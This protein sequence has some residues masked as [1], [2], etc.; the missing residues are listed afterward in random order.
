MTHYFGGSDALLERLQ[1]AVSQG[2]QIVFVVGSPLTAP[3]EH[4]GRGVM[5]VDAVVELIREEFSANRESRDL[6]NSALKA[7]G[8]KSYQHAFE[9][10]ILRRGVDYANQIVRRAVQNSYLGSICRLDDASNLEAAERDIENWHLSPAVESLGRIL[11]DRDLRSFGTTLTTNFDPLIQIAIARAGGSSY[12]TMLHREGNLA[13]TRADAAHIVHLHGSWR[14]SD[15][16]HTSRQLLQERPQLK[17]SLSSVAKNALIV[18]IGYG[19]W[20]DII[21]GT[22]SEL[23]IDDTSYPE[24]AW[25]FYGNSHADIVA[26]NTDIL[27]KLRAGIDRGRVSLYSGIDCHQFFPNLERLLMQGSAKPK[28]EAHESH[29]AELTVEQ[30]KFAALIDEM[31]AQ[32]SPIN[33]VPRTDVWFGRDVEL[34]RIRQTRAGVVAITG[35]GGQGKSSLASKYFGECKQDGLFEFFDW[36]DCREQGNTI[37][38]AICSTIEKATNGTIK[39][40]DIAKRPVNELSSILTRELRDRRALL[41]FDNVDHY[42]DLETNEPLGALKSVVEAVLNDVSGI[43]LIFTARPLVCIEHPDFVELRLT[44]LVEDEAREL[45]Q[46]RYGKTIDPEVFVKLFSLTAGHPLW[47]SIIA[48][49]CFGNGASVESILSSFQN[50]GIELPKQMLRQTWEGLN[51][52]QQHVLR[53]LAELERPESERNIEDITELNYNK[54][55]KALIK[56]RSLC[57]IERK[58]ANGKVEVIDLHPLIRQFVREE[59]PRKERESFIGKVIIY[60]DK[61][62]FQ[63]KRKP[64]GPIP[65]LIL[66]MWVHKIDLLINSNLYQQAIDGLFEVM[67][68]LDHNGFNEEISRLAKRIFSSI[69][70][71]E[72][73]SAYGNFDKLFN[74][75]M[76]AIV[77]VEGG[78]AVNEW[79]M[80]YEES[81]AG[82]GAQYINF[83]DLQ[84]YKHWFQKDHVDAIVWAEKGEA[85]KKSSNVD[86]SFQCSHTLAL[87]QRDSG[88][89]EPAFEYFKDGLSEE[90]IFSMESEGNR[91]GPF[92]G[93]LG[94]CYYFMGN[95][96]QAFKAYQ[97]SARRLDDGVSSVIDQ[98]YIRH[99][100]GQLL[101]TMGR[102]EDAIY[103]FRA[104]TEK[105]QRIAPSLCSDA[106]VEIKAI[107][108]DHP[109]LRHAEEAP[110][111]RCENRF[112][113]WVVEK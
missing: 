42:I 73:V 89:L 20:D 37:N 76:R 19:G 91:N 11:A 34:N 112:A 41:V 56:L 110:L 79:L 90:Q 67:D 68:Q 48:A 113:Q 14:G 98:G 109:G 9:F 4:R 49:Q 23:V 85:L 46:Y 1:F 28:R 88:K 101:R 81:I 65:T 16:L 29:A 58:I 64:N 53:T 7:A 57:L 18:A 74:R 36:K 105:W 102:V 97:I 96:E 54:L 44:G 32:N 61:K 107:L 84:A 35:I 60:L 92:F 111:W 51:A 40:T 72:A 50:N 17:A 24:V 87:A 21:T 75:C 55:G 66:E 86:T 5:G 95:Y 30:A 82:K 31:P 83:C 6:L 52:N 38:L 99:W 3:T 94:R 63:F 71:V 13:Q 10:L 22:L 27:G 100:A 33:A 47:L 43:S 39:V 25:T 26:Q 12:T 77:E 80:K 62:I 108:A 8:Q 106:T 70:W 78:G 69:E 59:F 45:F 103:C 93:N 2:K 15:T 104:A